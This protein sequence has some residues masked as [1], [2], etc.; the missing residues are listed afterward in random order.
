MAI[1]DFQQ[2]ISILEE[3][4]NEIKLKLNIKKTAYSIHN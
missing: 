1:E 2:I 4:L 3:D